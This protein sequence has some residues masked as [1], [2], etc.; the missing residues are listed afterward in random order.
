MIHDWMRMLLAILLGNLVYFAASPFLPESIQHSL[1]QL[2]AGLL[3]D[4]AICVG[5]YLLVRKKP[6]APE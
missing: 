6:K 1:Y 4:F 5:I 3:L 2:D